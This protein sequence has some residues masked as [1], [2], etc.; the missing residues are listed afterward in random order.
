MVSKTIP[1]NFAIL[2]S[3]IIRVGLGNLVVAL[4]AFIVS[5]ITAP[6]FFAI[7]VLIGTVIGIINLSLLARTIKS[8]FLFEPD[9]VQGFVTK[10]YYLRLLATLLVIGILVSKNLA[11]P[12]GLIIGL[13]VI[14]TATLAATIYFAKHAPAEPAPAVVSRGIKQGKESV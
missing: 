14:M 2:N 12:I 9:K 3:L 5:A 1:V 4:V 10:R 6:L 13:S 7:S 8:G 11:D